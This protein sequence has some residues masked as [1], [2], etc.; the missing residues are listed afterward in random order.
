MGVDWYSCKNCSDTFPDCGDYVWCECG[1]H[2]CSD[3]C[4]KADGYEYEE[5]EDGDGDIVEKISCNFCRKE[6]FE[7]YELLGFALDKLGISRIQL[8]KLFK[9]TK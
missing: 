9:E 1:E 6:D 7:D 8:V 5:F 4:A 2:W 3:K